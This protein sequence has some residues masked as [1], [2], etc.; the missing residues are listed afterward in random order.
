MEGIIGLIVYSG[1]I[2][3]FYWL[4]YVLMKKAVKNGILEAKQEE[5]EQKE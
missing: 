5:K 3:F 4:W 2:V 1:L